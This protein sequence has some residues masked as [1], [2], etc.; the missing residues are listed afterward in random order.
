MRENKNDKRM[1]MTSEKHGFHLQVRFEIYK[2][3]EN[4]DS[5]TAEGSYTKMI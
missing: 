4:R 2:K 5:E 3:I 1:S